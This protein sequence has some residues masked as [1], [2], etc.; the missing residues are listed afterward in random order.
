M[1]STRPE[2]RRARQH[3]RLASEWAALVAIG[4]VLA[5]TGPFASADDSSAAATDHSRSDSAADWTARPYGR[6]Q[7]TGPSSRTAALASTSSDTTSNLAWRSPQTKSRPTATPS[8]KPVTNNARKPFEGA[9]EQPESGRYPVVPAQATLALGPAQPID[10][11]FGDLAQR[12]HSADSIAEFSD[13]TTGSE[14]SDEP[15]RRAARPRRIAAQV[16]AAPRSVLVPPH[17]PHLVSEET[18]HDTPDAQHV[19]EPQSDIT[20]ISEPL[21]DENESTIETS[22]PSGDSDLP[23]ASGSLPEPEDAG[24]TSLA[25]ED[26]DQP[27]RPRDERGERGERGERD[28]MPPG[29]RKRK[30]TACDRTYNDRDCCEG[31]RQCNAALDALQNATIDKISLDITPPFDPKTY[32]SEP[33]KNRRKDKTSTLAKSP[34]RVWSDQHGQVLATGRLHDFRNS[35][36]IIEEASGATTAVAVD[37][38]GTDELCFLNA[39]WSLPLECRLRDPGLNPRCWTSLT[40]TWT[41]S[42]LC[43]K[44]LYFED[45]QLER[46]GHTVGPIRQ[47]LLS[48]A[49]FVSHIAILPYNMGVNTSNECMYA[50]GHY[51]PGNCAPRMINAFPFSL[52]GATYQAAAVTGLAGALP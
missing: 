35:Q 38:L 10:D 14:W 43:H 13:T 34:S 27:Q 3:E 17:E 45:E 15:R 7:G 23:G 48:A 32:A 2:G 6:P 24:D 40:Y 49:H 28:E 11:P 19:D 44:P 8:Q 50:L 37:R 31:D 25:D 26:A 46:Y 22:S 30:P 29:A 5:L 36:V 18:G 1:P 47:P 16:A 12:D 42:A 20:E 33:K 52:R 41:A 21:P 51:R 39:Y 9:A 4:L